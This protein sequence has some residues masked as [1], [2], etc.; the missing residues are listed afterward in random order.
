[1]VK[2]AESVAAAT[3]VEGAEPVASYSS[4][5]LRPAATTDAS[6]S[7]ETLLPSVCTFALFYRFGDL[8]LLIPFQQIGFVSLPDLLPDTGA[9]EAA[10]SLLQN[11]AHSSST[12]GLPR[13][14][15]NT[16]QKQLL[17]QRPH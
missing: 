16:H 6:D 4:R 7:T 10:V 9:V 14:S 12:R 2:P 11:R 15:K 8:K 5:S 3:T 17:H 13:C 1:M